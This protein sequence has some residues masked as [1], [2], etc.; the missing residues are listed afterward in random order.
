MDDEALC[1]W[2]TIVERKL[3]RLQSNQIAM[4]GMVMFLGDKLGVGAGAGTFFNLGIHLT[5]AGW[6]VMLAGR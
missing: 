3:F 6:I 1:Q 4:K 2:Q 5:W